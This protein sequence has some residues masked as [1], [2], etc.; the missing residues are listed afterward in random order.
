MLNQK[1]ISEFSFKTAIADLIII[2][3]YETRNSF[4]INTGKGLRRL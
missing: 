4:E 1:I 3:G 2:A